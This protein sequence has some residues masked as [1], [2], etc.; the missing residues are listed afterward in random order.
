M[1]KEL[2]PMANVDRIMRTAI[3]TTAKITKEAKTLMQDV[4][5]EFISF[6]ASEAADQV[7]ILLNYT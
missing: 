4:A 3:P 2:L 6:I 7:N 5:C 1:D